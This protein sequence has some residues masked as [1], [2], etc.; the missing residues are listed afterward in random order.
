MSI[1]RVPQ[2][3]IDLSNLISE[4]QTMDQRAA[5]EL[6]NLFARMCNL[7]ASARESATPDVS[8]IATDASALDVELTTWAA[9]A[10]DNLQISIQPADP[11]TKAYSDT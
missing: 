8:K 4:S 9:S 10:P 7:G 11:T 5:S 3:L 2:D 6:M 1:Q